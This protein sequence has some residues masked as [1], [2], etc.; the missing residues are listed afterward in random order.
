MLLT[1][2]SSLTDNWD[3]IEYLKGDPKLSMAEYFPMYLVKGGKKYDAKKN[4]GRRKPGRKL[5]YSNTGVGLLGYL[6]EVITEK[7]FN[8]YCN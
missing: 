3:A 1:H 2:T 7:P 6:L 4:F 8:T 5:E